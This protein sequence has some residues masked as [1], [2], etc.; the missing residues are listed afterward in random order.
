MVIKTTGSNSINKHCMILSLNLQHQL[1]QT[2]TDSVQLGH[3][4]LLPNDFYNKVCNKN[5]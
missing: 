3:M 5:L 1:S 4:W 2:G